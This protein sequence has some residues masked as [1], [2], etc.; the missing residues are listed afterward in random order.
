MFL[1]FTWIFLKFT[2]ET[3]K[4]FLR[5]GHFYKWL[6]KYTNYQLIF[7]IFFFQKVTFIDSASQFQAFF[8]TL[9]P[10]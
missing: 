2:P 3:Q 1:I 4:L 8:N 9:H 10:R 6:R 5:V 7:V